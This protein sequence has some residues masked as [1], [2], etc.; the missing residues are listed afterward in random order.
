MFLF[1][2]S[3]YVHAYWH[4]NVP[5]TLSNAYILGVQ[6]MTGKILIFNF[7]ILAY[8]LWLFSVSLGL[9]QL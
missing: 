8:V 3:Q 6:E 1:C 2:A 9:Y 4:H 5:D 7:R